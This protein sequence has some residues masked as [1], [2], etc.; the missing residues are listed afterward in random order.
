MP[1][2]TMKSNEKVLLTMVT[3]DSKGNVVPKVDPITWSTAH[4]SILRLSANGV[5]SDTQWVYAQGPVGIGDVTVTDGNGLVKTVQVEVVAGVASVID[6]TA[7]APSQ[8]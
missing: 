6:V 1:I 5:L 4:P 7:G 8:G 2:V 3:K